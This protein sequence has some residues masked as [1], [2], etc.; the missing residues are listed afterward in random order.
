MATPIKD[1]NLS[2]QTI[3]YGDL[4]IG[5]TGGPLVQGST[6]RSTPPSF[7]I[8][9]ND[10]YDDAGRTVVS[11]KIQLDVQSVFYADSVDLSVNQL[12]LVRR[13]L[14][15]PRKTLSFLGTGCGLDD[16]VIDVGWGP[17]PI[18]CTFQMHGRQTA[19]LNW[20]VEYEIATCTVSQSLFSTRFKAFVFS[21]NYSLDDEGLLTR[22]TVGYWE[23]APQI[24]GGT[25]ISDQFREKVNVEVPKGFRRVSQEYPESPDKTRMDFQIVDVQ[26]AGDALPQFIS[27]GEGNF[28]IAS[29]GAGF[30]KGAASLDV[31]LTVAPGVPPNF[32]Y[33]QFFLIANQ[34]QVDMQEAGSTIIPI[35]ISISR[36][37]FERSRTSRYSMQ[38]RVTNCITEFLGEAFWKPLEDSGDW[39]AWQQSISYMWHQRGIA[40][41]ESNPQND[42]RINLCTGVSEITLASPINEPEKDNSAEEE[43]FQCANIDP[44]KS[45]LDYDVIV[46]IQ[47][48]SE[49]TYHRQAVDGSVT[50]PDLGDTIY[51]TEGIKLGE[52]FDGTG[53]EDITEE[54]G[55]PT[56]YVLV[57]AKGLR[58]QYFPVLPELKEIDGQDV[59][60]VEEDIET[61]VAFNIGCPVY[62]MRGW[63]KYRVKGSISKF[64]E[65]K[66]DPTICGTTETDQQQQDTNKILPD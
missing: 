54:T 12:K 15:E 51:G 10:N 9:V 6:I 19:V 24:P 32:A 28:L 62:R 48:A 64:N 16:E 26:L 40:K 58:V 23:I 27:R 34:K 56:Q 8:H 30:S 63:R 31:I 11:Q 52:S 43:L 61:G 33:L 5:G 42:D 13:E 7:T 4:Q 2:G 18:S 57:M 20:S 53:K 17:R 22:T 45:W 35:G 50:K 65:N 47:K 66:E 29:E 14:M 38:W 60:L 25:Q 3:Q 37:L 59:E 39:E 36:G 1:F 44:K 49:K 41:V 46:R 21:Q 55:L